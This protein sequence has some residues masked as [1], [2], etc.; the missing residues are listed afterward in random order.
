[1]IEETMKGVEYVAHPT[2]EQYIEIDEKAR[3]FT[4]QL[5]H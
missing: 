3:A 1:V 5:I 4:R 2:L